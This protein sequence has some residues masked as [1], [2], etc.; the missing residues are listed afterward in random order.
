ME[1]RQNCKIKNQF[2]N[3]KEMQF[4]GQMQFAQTSDTIIQKI[5]KFEKT[6][7]FWKKK[8]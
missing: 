5:E 8:L 2:D 7:I 4:N 1:R 6:Q 3:S